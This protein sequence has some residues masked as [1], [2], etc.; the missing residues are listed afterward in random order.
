MLNQLMIFGQLSIGVVSAA[1]SGAAAARSKDQALA[2]YPTLRT[3]LDR[4]ERS[5]ILAAERRKL[6]VARLGR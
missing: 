1:V 5:G 3:A 6:T 4:A 2:G